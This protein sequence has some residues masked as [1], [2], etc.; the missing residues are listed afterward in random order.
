MSCSSGSR[1]RRRATLHPHQRLAETMTTM[2]QILLTSSVLL[3]AA[4]SV[5][6]QVVAPVP[7]PAP[8]PPAAPVVRVQPQAAIVAW[9]P[10][11]VKVDLDVTSL[12]EH[13]KWAAEEAKWA[14]DGA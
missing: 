2:K 9:T 3:S 14:V 8:L 5:S 10:D 4:G 6:A 7:A 13:A 12:K 11:Q 1:S